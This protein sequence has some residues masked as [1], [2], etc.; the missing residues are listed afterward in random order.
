MFLGK[1]KTRWRLPS[2]LATHPYYRS[3]GSAPSVAQRSALYR[4]TI[5]DLSSVFSFSLREPLNI[6]SISDM[7]QPAST[8]S[9]RDLFNAA[10]QDY[11]N[12][13]GTALIDHPF[14][15][16]LQAC[17]SVGSISVILQEQAQV[18]SNY[19]RDDGR[20][21]K[22][23]KASIDVLYM[24]SNSTVL[25]QG[26]GLVCLKLFT[27]SSLSPILFYSHFRLQ[28]QYSLASPSYFPYVPFL[29]PS[30]NSVTSESCRRSKTLA[31]AMTH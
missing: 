28:M 2:T 12:Q 3:Q 26:I 15:K 6:T 25:A 20:I 16:Q 7:S 22:S 9:F 17:D 21:L 19:R 11:E 24:L 5:C 14:S 10:L 31:L 27:I 18:F 4:F 13:T 30:A 1:A 29:I 8:F 23:I